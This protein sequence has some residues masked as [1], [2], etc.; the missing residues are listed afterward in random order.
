[1]KITENQEIKCLASFQSCST[2]LNSA[3]GT[4]PSQDEPKHEV[5]VG[6]LLVTTEAIHLTSFHWLCD[7]VSD[8]S[9]NNQITLLQPMSNLVELENVTKT[10]FTLSFM[11]ELENTLE[12]WNFVFE[13]YPR[14]AYTLECIDEIW[15]KIFCV[16]LISDDQIL[17]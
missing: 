7:H 16:P 15:Q 17:S 1:M 10:T 13:S 6:V 9:A 14:I 8:K 12:K 3:I 2:S 5:D 4:D 11:E